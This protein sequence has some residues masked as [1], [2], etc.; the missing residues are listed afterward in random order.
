MSY[1]SFLGVAGKYAFGSKSM[2]CA[3]GDSSTF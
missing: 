2:I 3:R 1:D